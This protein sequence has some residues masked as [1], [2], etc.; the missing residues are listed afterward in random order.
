MASIGSSAQSSVRCIGYYQHW[1]CRLAYN[2][3]RTRT[4]HKTVKSASA[5]RSHH[6]HFHVFLLGNRENVL[7]STALVDYEFWLDLALRIF[8]HES[9]QP[10]LATFVQRP[11][12]FR[13]VS[14]LCGIV[15]E[16]IL[17]ELDNMQCNH[18]GFVILGK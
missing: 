2:T 7:G 15:G 18:R 14:L 9:L 13:V 11:G 16:W 12:E 10:N 5:V 4:Q 6:D 8:L 3:V 17:P 1:A